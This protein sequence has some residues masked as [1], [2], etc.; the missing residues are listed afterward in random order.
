MNIPRRFFD[1]TC[2]ANM[3]EFKLSVTVAVD[4]RGATACN[5]QN[6]RASWLSRGTPVF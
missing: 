1:K 4:F 6:F 3:T 5:S 2:L